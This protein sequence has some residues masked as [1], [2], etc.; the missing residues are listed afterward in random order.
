MNETK[1]KQMRD[2]IYIYVHKPWRIISNRQKI[3][4]WKHQSA[5]SQWN[6]I[7]EYAKNTDLFFRFFSLF[8]SAYTFFF[9][10]SAPKIDHFIIAQA[11]SI[12]HTAHFHKV[13]FLQTVFFLFC[14]SCCCCCWSA[15]IRCAEQNL[16][17]VWLNDRILYSFRFTPIHF[18]PWHRCKSQFRMSSNLDRR[19][20][21]SDRKKWKKEMKFDWQRSHESPLNFRRQ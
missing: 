10:W 12:P 15:F 20:S 14:S 18:S 17:C 16:K 4:K 11:H 19:F 3:S 8:G 13:I 9:C 6:E 5:R 21:F 1:W 7:G 2:G